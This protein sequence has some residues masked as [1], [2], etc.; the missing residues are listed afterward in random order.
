MHTQFTNE[1]LKEAPSSTKAE[2]FDWRNTWYPASF[3]CDLPKDK[4]TR[5]CIYDT[6]YVLFFDADGQLGCLRDLCPHRAARL[7]DGQVIDGR[8]ECLYHGWQYDRN[9]D[10]QFIPQ[11]IPGKD[12]P[13]RSCVRNFP[14]VVVQGIIWV[15]PGDADRADPALITRGFDAGEDG[16]HEVTFQ[17]DL[18]YDQSYLIE[19]VIDVAHIHIAHDGVRGG[20][21]RAAAKP[22]HFDVSESSIDGFRATFR[23]LGLERSPE[24]PDI[25]GAHVEFIAPNLVRYASRYSDST[26]IAGLDLFSLPTGKGR[27][28]LLYRKYSNFTPWLERIKPRWLE[29]MTLCLILEQDMNVVVGQHEEIENSGGALSNVWLP[30]KTSDRLVLEYRKW[31]DRYGDALPFYRGL[32][33]AKNSGLEPGNSLS[34]HDRHH[35]HTKICST[36]QAAIRNIDRAV[37]L[38]RIVSVAGFALAIL[39]RNTNASFGLVLLAVSTLSMVALLRRFRTRF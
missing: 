15:W 13:I 31:L 6:G 36:C 33:S 5:F 2:A 35:L 22:L 32:I 21:L 30:I 34:P 1:L 8:L 9:G 20:G 11:M 18:P 12:Y 3:F 38:L 23:T 37:L 25:S 29:H 39:L 27:C 19:N 26:L 24:S 16:I 4:P 14:V 28:R 17:M 10:C 7:S